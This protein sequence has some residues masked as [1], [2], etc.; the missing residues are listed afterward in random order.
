MSI[1][2]RLTVRAAVVSRDR[3]VTG[4]ACL[5]GEFGQGQR[6]FGID[7]NINGLSSRASMRVTGMGRRRIS[8]QNSHDHHD[9]E[10]GEQ[11][12]ESAQQHAEK[13]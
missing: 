4:G 8:R 10:S 13:G 6:N 12:H 9:R 3:A 11:P 5:S 7:G 1:A 2:G